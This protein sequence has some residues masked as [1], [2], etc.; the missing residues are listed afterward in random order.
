MTRGQVKMN[1]E[2]GLTTIVLIGPLVLM[3]VVSFVLHFFIAL[4]ER[5]ERRAAWTA[6]VAYVL[7]TGFCLFGF[8]EQIEGY[9]FAAPLA[10]IPSGLIVYWY[11]CRDFREGWIDGPGDLHEGDTIA[12]HDWRVGL[13]GVLAVLIIL[14]VKAI[15]R[16]ASV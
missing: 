14:A 5:P 9:E 12:N 11:W 13:A 7:V 2:V 1:A 8:A 3:A 16:G 15:V 4:K 10:A 6:G